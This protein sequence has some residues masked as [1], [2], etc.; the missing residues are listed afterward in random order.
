MDS[1]V[2]E[3]ARAAVP[4]RRNTLELAARFAAVNGRELHVPPAGTLPSIDNVIAHLGVGGFH[5]SHLAYATDRLLR[6]SA[7]PWGI[8]CL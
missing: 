4:L 1:V 2:T 7:S 6:G 5:R 8:R 3:R